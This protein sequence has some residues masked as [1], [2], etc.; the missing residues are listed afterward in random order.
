MSWFSQWLL[1]EGE[2]QKGRTADAQLAALD[3]AAFE[4]GTISADEFARR[5]RAREVESADTYLAQI[6]G[7]FVEGWQEGERTVQGAVASTV[8]GAAAVV[9]DVVGAPL[10][11]VVQGLP[12][13]AWL[14]GIIAL[15]G[16]A[17]LLPSAGLAAGAALRK[18][19]K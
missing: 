9:R 5:N 7:A 16:W 15:L 12:W 3:A 14:L 19:W 10:V 4:A 6:D 17:G 11:G 18:V 8:G 13:W 2:V 1:G